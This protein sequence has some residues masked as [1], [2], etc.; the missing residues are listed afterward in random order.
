[1]TNE[2]RSCGHTP[3]GIGRE[4]AQPQLMLCTVA[5]AASPLLLPVLNTRT[6]VMF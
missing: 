4:L 5:L 2:L 3:L 1:M 6:A